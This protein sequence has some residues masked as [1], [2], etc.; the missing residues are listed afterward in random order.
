MANGVAKVL[1]DTRES[2]WNGRKQCRISSRGKPLT[3][4]SLILDISMPVMNGFDAARQ[5]PRSVP[6]AEFMF[7][8]MHSS[9]LR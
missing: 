4:D 9:C 3:P 6:K 1:E 5:I 2:P 7:L 8:T